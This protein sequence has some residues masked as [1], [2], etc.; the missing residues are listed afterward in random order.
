MGNPSHRNQEKKEIKWL[1]T[2]KNEVKQLLFMDDMIK[3]I[4]SPKDANN[5]LW[6]CLLIGYT[7][8][9]N[10]FSPSL[11]S[12]SLW[13]HGLHHTSLPH[14][15]PTPRGCSNSCQ[16]SRWCLPTI[17]FS[18]ILFSCLQSLLASGSFPMSH[19]FESSNQSIGVSASKSV[20][21][22]NIQD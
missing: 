5:K 6:V 17:S 22:M 7:P 2:G 20:L 9:Q 18:I 4:E 14:P 19:F 15:T 10:Q 11:L 12:V 13:T 3:Y 8:I 21:P 1:Q 16:L